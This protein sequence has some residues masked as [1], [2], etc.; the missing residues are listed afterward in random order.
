MK[1]YDP[2]R[3]LA[4][5]MFLLAMVVVGVTIAFLIRGAL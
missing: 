1:I 2:D 3:R 4:E 5:G